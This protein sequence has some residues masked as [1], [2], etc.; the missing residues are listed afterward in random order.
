MCMPGFCLD[1]VISGP[2][3]AAIDLLN[4]APT[5]TSAMHNLCISADVMAAKPL[6]AAPARAGPALQ[7][8]G[9]I[10]VLFWLCVHAVH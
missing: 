5:C 8:W 2:Y 9:A 10:N 1:H 3:H 6:T 7:L 4:A